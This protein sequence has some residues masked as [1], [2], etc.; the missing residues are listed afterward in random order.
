MDKNQIVEQLKDFSQADQK[1]VY[2][3]IL[4]LLPSDVTSKELG[5]YIAQKP[6]EEK[7]KAVAQFTA[8]VALGPPTQKARDRLWLVVVI[9]FAIVLVGGFVTLALGVFM[10]PAK[11]GVKPEL[12]LTTFTSVVGFLAGLFVPSPAQPK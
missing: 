11:D 7:D 4:S 3:N 5:L 12:I 10:T 2:Q 8:N 6:S 1:D 9:A